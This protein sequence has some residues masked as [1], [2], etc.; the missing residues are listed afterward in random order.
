MGTVYVELGAK[1]ALVLLAGV[2][3]I[4]R[5][6]EKPGFEDRL[7]KEYPELVKQ[8]AKVL[9]TTKG[10]QEMLR[11]VL[12]AHGVSPYEASPIKSGA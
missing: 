10:L 5:E 6:L 4:A 7:G 2:D 12:V 8:R 3:I 11:D 9:A 1:H